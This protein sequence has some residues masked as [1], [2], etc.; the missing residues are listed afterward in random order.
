MVAM[1]TAS[2][3]E[4]FI[5]AV[6]NW[7][8]ACRDGSSVLRVNTKSGGAD[9]FSFDPDQWHF[10]PRYDIA[11]V[12]LGIDTAKHET[13]FIHESAFISQAELERIKVG[14]GEN[15]FMVGRFIDH[16][17]GFR[18]LPA[19]R[20]GNISVMPSRM[21]QPNGVKADAYCI[22]LHSRSG[23]SG[24]PVLMYRA[25]G[26]D[27]E[28]RLGSGKDAR[29]L[30]SGTNYLGLLGIH[31]A[32]FPEEWEIRHGLK[33]NVDGESNQVPIL[34]NGSSIRGLS[35]M[36]CVLPAWCIREVLDLP[37]LK[38][39]RDYGNA[40]ILEEAARS[41]SSSPLAESSLS[42]AQIERRRDDAI[43]RALDTPPSP[44]RRAPP[45]A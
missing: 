22:D 24:S 4:A 35:G 18:N 31:F 27:L 9:I 16:D 41:G 32:Q 10:D 17:G 5:Y 38:A 20:F 15:V 36:T 14:P 28:E 42:E 21:E 13:T 39:G 43:R 45:D 33:A 2:P 44:R 3:S 26:Y 30:V 7:H 11:V 25:P 6:T 40:K 19:V 37:K 34:R 29:I 12:P 8:V 1:P 23:Y